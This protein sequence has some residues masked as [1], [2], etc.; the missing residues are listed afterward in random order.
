MTRLPVFLLG[1][2]LL[3]LSAPPAFA[4][5]ASPNIL[6][7]IAD[8]M[9][10]DA[11]PCYDVGA[12]TPSM[13]TLEALCEDGLVFENAYAA[14]MCSPTRATIM[15]GRYGFRTGVGTAVGLR[16][17][18]GLSTDETSLFTFLDR[19]APDHYAHAVIGKWHL[20]TNAY[21]GADHPEL[22]GVDYYAGLLAGT[23]D[24]YGIWLR[25]EDGVSEEVSGYVTTVFTDE[26]IDWIDRQGDDPWFLWLAHVAPH[27][28]LHLPPAHLHSYGHL[29]GTQ[30]DMDAR[31]LDYYFAALEAMDTEIGRLLN[32]MT[33]DVRENTVVLFIGDN[34][35]PARTIQSPFE[36]QRA[37][38]SLFEGGTHVPL[39]VAGADV[40]RAGERDDALVNSTDLFATIADLAGV[41]KAA[42][43]PED[44]ISFAGLLSGVV[45]DEWRGFAYTEHFGQT[46]AVVS[47]RRAQR[48]GWA[49]RDERWK[50]IE[51]ENGERFLFDLASDPFESN[52]L[53]DRLASDQNLN[54]MADRLRRQADA[55]R[56][57]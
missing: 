14:P 35:T 26:S 37:K 25:T 29:T 21:G 38:A 18:G 20:A 36:R 31:R 41:P 28:P 23:L 22:M 1:A 27:L 56:T 54:A 4:Q 15:T 17:R 24:D 51:L 57:E 42:T 2:G 30:A 11:S 33:A 3:C 34:G 45:R 19:H 32:S 40:T 5:T 48:F 6:L 50:Y 52:N 8:D 16:S 12:R 7:I 49:I 10:L 13:P 53:I 43:G 9:G 46:G 55:L 47:P 44:S 39:I